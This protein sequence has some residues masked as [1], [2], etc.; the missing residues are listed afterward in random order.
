MSCRG[1]WKMSTVS[2][3]TSGRN[4]G[5]TACDDDEDDERKGDVK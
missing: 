1:I 4:C 3:K 5:T 2:M